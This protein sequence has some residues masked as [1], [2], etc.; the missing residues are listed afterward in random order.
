[1]RPTTLPLPPMTADQLAVF[2]AFFNETLAG[3]A[4][5]FDWRDPVTLEAATIRFVTPPPPD[6]T[7]S[8]GYF[9]VTCV[10]EIL[11]S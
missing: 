3:G 10:A 7:K 6:I 5:P 8:E 9:R 2:K 11:P 1:V 4:L